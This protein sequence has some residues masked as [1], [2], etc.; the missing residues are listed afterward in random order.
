MRMTRL[1][2]AVTLLLAISLATPMSA[3]AESESP[4]AQQASQEVEIV[5]RGNVL[6][7]VG[8][9]GLDAKIYNLAGVCVMAFKVEGN[10]RHYDINLRKGCYIVKVGNTA[11]KVF[12]K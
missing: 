2:L 7:I 9:N 12:V 5:L 6:R 3:W 8:A 11:R 10:D 4:A 1:L